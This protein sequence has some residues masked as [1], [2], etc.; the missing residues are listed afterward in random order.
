MGRNH[1]RVDANGGRSHARMS[2]VKPR[3]DGADDEDDDGGRGHTEFDGVEADGVVT[4]TEDAA[5]SEWPPK[6]R[7]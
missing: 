4:Q 7:G 5:A 6:V 3:C 2:A 1:S